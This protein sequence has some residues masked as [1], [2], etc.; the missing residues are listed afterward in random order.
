MIIRWGRLNEQISFS[1]D[2]AWTVFLPTFC[3]QA[4]VSAPQIPRPA[5]VSLLKDTYR[6]LARPAAK[7]FHV[8]FYIHDQK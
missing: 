1:V 8:V 5:P 4:I 2:V 3:E 6:R 7:P